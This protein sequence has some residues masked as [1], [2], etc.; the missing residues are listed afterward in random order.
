M[1]KLVFSRTRYSSSPIFSI[2]RPAAVKG[3]ARRP[4]T[5]MAPPIVL[6]GKIEWLVHMPGGRLDQVTR[7]APIEGGN[8]HVP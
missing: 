4:R 7:P 1:G 6:I 5:G 2:H 3:G 8:T